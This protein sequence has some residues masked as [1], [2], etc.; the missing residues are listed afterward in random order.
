[1]FKHKPVHRHGDAVDTLIG[2]K[3]VIRGDVTFTG[4]LYVEGRIEGKVQAEAGQPAMLIV[5]ESGNVIGE[6]HA[7]T[8]IINGNLQGDVHSTERV[9][10]ASKARVLGNVHYK[11][12]EMS[13]GATLTG[14]L[15]HA[16]AQVLAAEVT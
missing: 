4:G 10:L 14:R 6:V 13:A 16:D 15:I 2:P 1:M 9:E 7:P 3:V 12:V 8:V 11:T 5:A